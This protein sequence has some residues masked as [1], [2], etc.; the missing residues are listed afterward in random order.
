MAKPF[1]RVA[2]PRTHLIRFRATDGELGLIRQMASDCGLSVS[3]F[4]RKQAL[5]RRFRS[6][7]AATLICRLT[8][9]TGEVRSLR[10]HLRADA[11]ELKQMLNKI[12]AEV[13]RI[14]VDDDMF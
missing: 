12:A 2:F 1:Q 6:R 5:S 10:E 9:L 8:E 14:S 4:V 7:I 13:E 11:P 3:S